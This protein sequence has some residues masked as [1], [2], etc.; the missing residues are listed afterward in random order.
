MKQLIARW[1]QRIFA[2]LPLSRNKILFVSY[3]GSQYGCSPKYLSEYIVRQHPEWKVVWAFVQP[4]RHAVAGVRKVKY[5]SLR[6]FYELGT[7]RV[8]VTN[9]RT[10]SLYRKRKGQHYLLTWHNSLRLKQI[11]YFAVTMLNTC[12]Q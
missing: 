12:W 3:Y 1:L 10:T 9:Y 4:G 7:S 11:E 6:Y 5:L 8:F 2:C